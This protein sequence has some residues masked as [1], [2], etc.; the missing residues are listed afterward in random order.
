MQTEGINNLQKELLEDAAKHILSLRREN[1][2]Y[3]ARLQMFD[4]IMLLFRTQPSWGGMMSN[5]Q[6]ED[7]VW[8]IENF[9]KKMEA[10]KVSEKL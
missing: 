9:I 7:I 5:G 10:G 3:S 2:I 1:S 6:G 8:R 4:D